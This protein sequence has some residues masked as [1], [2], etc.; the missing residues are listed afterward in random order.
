MRIMWE[1]HCGLWE[2]LL[3]NKNEKKNT[4]WPPHYAHCEIVILRVFVK[5]S[6]PDQ[7]STPGTGARIISTCPGDQI[8]VRK[9]ETDYC[10]QG[11]IAPKCDKRVEHKILDS[12]KTNPTVASTSSASDCKNDLNVA[13]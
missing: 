7:L 13:A 4:F 11:L 2:G 5:I 12:A 8:I 1:H 3:T 9:L 10:V 6:F